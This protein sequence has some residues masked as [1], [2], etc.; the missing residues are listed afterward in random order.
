M[1]AIEK[2][3]LLDSNDTLLVSDYDYSAFELRLT[4]NT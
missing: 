4:N 3:G 2:V 1:T